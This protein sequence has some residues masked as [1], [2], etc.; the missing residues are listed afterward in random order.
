MK[1]KQITVTEPLLPP[2]EEFIPYLERV[3]ESK[4]S[5]TVICLGFI[6]TIFILYTK[7]NFTTSALSKRSRITTQTTMPTFANSVFT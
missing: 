2:L 5:V 6:V 3:W 4:G 1:P 7:G